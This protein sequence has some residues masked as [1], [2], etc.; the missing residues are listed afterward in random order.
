MR[1]GHALG[2]HIVQDGAKCCACGGAELS[3]GDRPI[4]IGQLTLVSADRPGHIN[5]DGIRPRLWGLLHKIFLQNFDNA[6]LV[7]VAVAVNCL[8]LQ[9][10]I[11][12]Q[13]YA[14]IG[15]AH[16]CDQIMLSHVLFPTSIPLRQLHTL[17]RPIRARALGPI[18]GKAIQNQ[19]ERIL[20]A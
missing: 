11:I 1:Q 12:G 6:G 16:V 17:F 9:L 8:G 15:A 2:L 19:G 10:S 7:R 4:E 13:S 5:T 18:V 3:A 14:G 20:P